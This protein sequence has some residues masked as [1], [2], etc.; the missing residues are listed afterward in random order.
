MNNTKEIKKELRELNQFVK[1]LEKRKRITKKLRIKVVKFFNN[2]MKE[3]LFFTGK[4]IP[5]KFNIDYSKIYNGNIHE[6]TYELTKPLAY[7]NEIY[8]LLKEERERFAKQLEKEK[9]L[10]IKSFQIKDQEYGTYEQWENLG[11]LLHYLDERNYKSPNLNNLIKTFLRLNF[12]IEQYANRTVKIKYPKFK[13][14]YEM[15][16]KG[17]LHDIKYILDDVHDEIYQFI[18]EGYEEEKEEENNT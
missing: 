13:D 17:N 9:E 2:N 1:D 11:E 8:R 5:Y 10:D 15:I 4:K 6:V 7:K 16:D 12:D 18:E 14:I 3:L